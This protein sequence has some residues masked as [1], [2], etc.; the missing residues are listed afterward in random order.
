VDWWLGGCYVLF[1]FSFFLISF[2]FAFKKDLDSFFPKFNKY[3]ES[4]TARGVQVL[5]LN[6]VDDQAQV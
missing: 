3:V 6:W 5:E 2:S 1:L 4:V